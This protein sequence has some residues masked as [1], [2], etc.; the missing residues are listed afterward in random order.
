MDCQ[1]KK[2]LLKK[3][4]KTTKVVVLRVCNLFGYPY[5]K[6]KNC[7]RLLINS[8]VKDLIT[9]NKFQVISSQFTLHYYLKSEE[10]FNGFLTNI[11][12]NID[13]GLELEFSSLYS[14][15]CYHCEKCGILEYYI[16]E[17]ITMRCQDC[18]YI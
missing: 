1:P 14:L 12:E 7:W 15:N 5:F 18:L 6:S 11:N 3:N 17:G 2:N 10:T 8:I 9:K 13:N 16:E 4:S